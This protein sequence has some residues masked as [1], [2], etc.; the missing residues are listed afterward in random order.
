VL[1]AEPKCRVTGIQTEELLRASH[2]KPWKS[3]DSSE[4]RLDG[5]NGLALSPNVDHLFDR[6]LIT[7]QD[8]GDML[9]ARALSDEDR[10]ALGI[11]TPINV[12]TF[13]ADQKG[14]LAYHRQYVY[15]G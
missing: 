4:E 13:N 3:C 6:G 7:F 10:S 11:S 15:R 12:G 2:I 8:N 5:N 14:Y 9:T 1:G